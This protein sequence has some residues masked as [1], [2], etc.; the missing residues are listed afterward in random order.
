[1]QE[2]KRSGRDR[3]IFPLDVP[4]E[5]DAERLAETLAGEVGMFKIGLELFVQ[6]GPKLVHKIV[7]QGKAGVFLDL[8]LHDIPVTVNR[9]MQRIADLGVTFATA[10]CGETPRMLEAA[11]Q[12]AGGQVGVLAVTVLTSVS[13][14]DIK[15]AGFRHP[16]RSEMSS[17]VLKR[18]G[19]AMELGCSGVVCSGKEVKTIKGS[20]GD[21]FVA[22]TPGIRPAWDNVQ[23]DDQQRI[24]TPADAIRDGA[25]YIV[26]GRPIRDAADPVEAA[27]RIAA[28]VESV[29]RP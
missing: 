26:I 25:D 29:A 14:L 17:L 11:V 3:I 19:M 12:G 7:Q 2:R 22:V 13:I 8:K 27:R 4:S 15:L 28:E 6:A 5:K 18:A 1:M 9:A 23:E 16:Y 20:L 21:E 24:T 10:H